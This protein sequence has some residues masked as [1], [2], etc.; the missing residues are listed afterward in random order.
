MHRTADLHLLASHGAPGAEWDEPA[1]GLWDERNRPRDEGGREEG[2]DGDHG[3]AAVGD[4]LGA[5]NELR[6]LGQTAH[7]AC[8]EGGGE[9]V[10][11]LSSLAVPQ[12][13]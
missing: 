5:L 12:A 4:L 10:L 7:G 3:E 8:R 2:Y 13:P 1:R 11:R 9:G 6:L